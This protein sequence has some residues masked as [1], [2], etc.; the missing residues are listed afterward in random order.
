MSGSTPRPAGLLD[1][2]PEPWPLE[3]AVAP[4]GRRREAQT[5]PRP[6]QGQS[7]GWGVGAHGSGSSRRPSSPGHL[8]LVS[9]G[10]GP[11]ALG[12]S[13]VLRSAEMRPLRPHETS[14]LTQPHVLRAS[15]K[16]DAG[17]TL[18]TEPLFTPL[19]RLGLRPSALPHLPQQLCALSGIRRSQEIPQAQVLGFARS[20]TGTNSNLS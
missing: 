3:C 1:T 16:Q 20:A 9:A 14:C 18:G 15:S 11:A 12:V 5:P 10:R 17:L 7:Q 19:R 2:L 13:K 8:Y 4:P 6:Q